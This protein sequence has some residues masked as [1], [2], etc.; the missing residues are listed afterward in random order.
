MPSPLTPTLPSLGRRKGPDTTL[1]LLLLMLL[2]LFAFALL[3]KCEVKHRRER[4][5]GT[6]VIENGVHGV[7][8]GFGE[9]TR[10]AI[11]GQQGEM[12]ATEA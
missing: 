5:I 9:I 6:V 2:S 4:A 7:W 12:T 11:G 1:H 10:K 8:R 3:I